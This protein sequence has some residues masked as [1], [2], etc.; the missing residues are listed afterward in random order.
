LWSPLFVQMNLAIFQNACFQP[1]P[2]QTD[3][4][5]VA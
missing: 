4:A 2:N 5:R 1:A 3:Q